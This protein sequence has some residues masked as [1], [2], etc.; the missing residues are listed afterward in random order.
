MSALSKITPDLT[1]IKNETGSEI[2]GP[3]NL[4]M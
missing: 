1:E 2:Y 3:L 4:N